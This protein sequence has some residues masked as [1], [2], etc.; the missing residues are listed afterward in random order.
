M[1]YDR[2][3]RNFLRTTALGLIAAPMVTGLPGFG[4]FED[5]DLQN[6]E[7]VREKKA[8]TGVKLNIREFGAV[9][10]GS[11]KDTVAIQQALDR[12]WMLGGG[13]VIVPEGNYLTG[14]IALKSN[15]LLRLEKDAIL[16]GTPDFNDY[17][18]MQVRREGEWRPIPC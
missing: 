8:A 13:E 5:P 18:I 6:R 17:P 7:S 12:C 2:T 16:T 15:T 14:A 9:G 1:D 4:K 10:D 11:T 3:R